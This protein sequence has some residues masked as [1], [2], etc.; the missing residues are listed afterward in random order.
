MK[1][2]IKFS[3]SDPFSTWSNKEVANDLYRIMEIKNRNLSQKPTQS[4]ANKILDKFHPV[5]DGTELSLADLMKLDF[6]Q[7]YSLL[8]SVKSNEKDNVVDQKSLQKVGEKIAK[9]KNTELIN[10]EQ[11]EDGINFYLETGK[12]YS[13]SHANESFFW[14][15]GILKDLKTSSQFSKTEYKSK[16]VT[17]KRSAYRNYKPWQFEL[18][19]LLEELKFPKNYLRVWQDLD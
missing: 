10:V 16:D 14:K 2:K 13:R 6:K 4:Q 12:G 18:V 3:A 19:D 11:D 9:L 15:D 1:V 17:N 7:I 5:I 8:K